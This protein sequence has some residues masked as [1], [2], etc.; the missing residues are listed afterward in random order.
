M[1][2]LSLDMKKGSGQDRAS[3][4]PMV[5]RTVLPVLFAAALLVGL[6][7]P[8]A[9]AQD[10]VF[11][12]LHSFTAD[13]GSAPYSGLSLGRD[14]NFYGVT[15]GGGPTGKGMVVRIT[16]AG[17]VTPL[18]GFSGDDG[19]NP[20][21]ALVQTADGSFYGT[22]SYEGAGGG[23]TIFK[24]AP[25][26]TLTTLYSFDSNRF[27]RPSG[28]TPGL[29]GN[30]YGTL[31]NAVFS[32]TPDGIVTIL[33]TLGSTEGGTP[34]GL[35]RGADGNFY[36]TAFA[37]GVNDRGT[38]FQVTPGG[39][40]KV[41]YNLS[42]D[43]PYPTA[44]A[45]G[46]DGNLYGSTEGNGS[47]NAGTIFQITPAGVFTI[48]H[49]FSTVADLHGNNGDGAVPRAALFQANDG[50]FYGSTS[51]GGANNSGAIF[52][53]TPAGVLTT[54]HQFSLEDDPANLY[55]GS[56]DGA[57]P[58]APLTQGGD[59]NIYG[60]TTEG[61]D[62]DDGT[63]F[64]LDL[65][66]LSAFSASAY[67]VDEAGG[68]VSLTIVRTSAAGAASVGFAT[69]DG[70]ALAGTDYSATSGTLTWADGDLSSLMVTVPV[71]DRGLSDGSTR[72][73]SVVLSDPVNTSLGSPASASVEIDDNDLSPPVLTDV[74][75]QSAV[76]GV[77]FTY[78]IAAANRPTSFGADGLPPGLRVDAATG[79]LT[80]EPS[81]AGKFTVTLHATNAAGTGS[82]AL[83]LTVTS[84]P[85]T[86]AVAG[87][88]TAQYGGKAAKLIFRRPAPG[89]AALTVYYKVK[90]AAKAGVDF[91]PLSGYVVFPPTVSQVALK[92]KPL[93]NPENPG[94]L[95]AKVI[96]LPPGDDSYAPGNSVPLKI[97][98]L[99]AK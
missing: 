85:V 26:G 25:N 52:R 27:T 79:L 88:G 13:E 99:A 50:N 94:R 73:F 51:R 64:A 76:A 61:G 71:L 78:Q 35:V 53:C 75:D 83:T 16:P 44:L 3:L 77:L 67:T 74:A 46:S 34:L 82:A 81:A 95:K 10:A 33:H 41:L 12:T 91:K 96:L 70:T 22:T 24:L 32:A 37:G 42:S 6:A 80:G 40:F 30:F 89:G 7:T 98:V 57:F 47:A 11:T 68:S 23:G 62:D 54:L 87:D 92:F 59:G 45:A 48:L 39:D 29:D 5:S 60:V 55:A 43:N 58:I 17:G 38:I 86:L 66:G 4:L 31:S 19:A 2:G 84:P 14:G 21:A 63:M 36:G 49:A 72:T 1:G 90:G 20:Q 18:H 97:A 9:C 8:R 69:R 56:P 28:L 65:N 93:D 15:Q